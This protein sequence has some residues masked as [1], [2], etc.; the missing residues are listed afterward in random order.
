[1]PN[2]GL[3]TT[4]IEFHKKTFDNSD[5]LNLSQLNEYRQ[6]IRIKNSP[7]LQKQFHDA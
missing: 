7:N 6:A 1:M 3:C 5:Y 4:K 2:R